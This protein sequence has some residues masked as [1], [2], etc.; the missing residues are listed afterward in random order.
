MSALRS[1]CFV[2]GLVSSPSRPRASRAATAARHT[3][4]TRASTNT[5]MAAGTPT[6]NPPYP[7]GTPGVAWG[8]DE[9]A[10]WRAHVG[11]IQRSYAEEV[12]AKLEPLKAG[13][14]L[15]VS[16]EHH[17][18]AGVRENQ[19]SEIKFQK[20]STWKFQLLKSVNHAFHTPCV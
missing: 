15:R 1:L 11:A 2:R 16:P 9:T 8:E 10:Q 18:P 19:S 7:V 6:P 12:L 20:L 13:R 17:S 4:A 3:H 14:P 5:N